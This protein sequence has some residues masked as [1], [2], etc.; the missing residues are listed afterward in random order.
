[1]LSTA[2]IYS[3]SGVFL[4]YQCVGVI[5]LQQKV[6]HIDFWNPVRFTDLPAF[7]LTGSD[8][9]IS[10]MTTDPKHLLK[11]MYIDYIRVLTEHMLI[12]SACL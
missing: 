5:I 8:K 10:V 7:D 11:R 1:M 6:N 3:I 4:L 9:V 12:G 2:D